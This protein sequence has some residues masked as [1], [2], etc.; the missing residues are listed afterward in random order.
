MNIKSTRMKCV[1]IDDE[2]LALNIIS[3]FCQRIGN[4]E[5]TCFSHPDKGIEY[6]RT[7]VPDLVFLDIQMGE[8]SGLDL[9][10]QIPEG[11]MLIFTTAFANYALEGFE[12]N[13]IDFLHK[14]FSFS[15]FSK[16]MEKAMKWKQMEAHAQMNASDLNNGTI[17]LRSEYKTIQIVLNQILYIEGMDNY[18]RIYLKDRPM[19]L[20]QI[21]MKQLLEFLPEKEFIRV[22]KSYIIPINKVCGYSHQKISLRYVSREIPI[23]RTYAR[24]FI[25]RMKQSNIG[26]Q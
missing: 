15:R 16:A 26:I 10:K 9:A 1:A 3:Q 25:S 8:V 11:V 23:G 19:I 12:L 20:S 17:S 5:I 4:I 6:V 14:P 18:A 24:D 21:T 2:P 13:A 7:H 22:H